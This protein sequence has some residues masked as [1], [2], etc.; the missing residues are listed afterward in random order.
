VIILGKVKDQL[1]KRFLDLLENR[2]NGFHTV[3]A[4]ACTFLGNAGDPLV[5]VAVDLVPLRKIELLRSLR[6]VTNNSMSAARHLLH[7]LRE[8]VQGDSSELSRASIGKFAP[9]V[10]LCMPA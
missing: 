9:R 1:V 5:I 3:A 4:D 6:L 10:K 7:S 2:A 8:A